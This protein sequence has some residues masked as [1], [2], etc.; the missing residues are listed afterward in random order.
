MIIISD[1]ITAMIDLYLKQSDSHIQISMLLQNLQQNLK[2]SD[3]IESSS[4]SVFSLIQKIIDKTPSLGPIDF[5]L[6]LS[7]IC[8]FNFHKVSNVRLSYNQIIHRCLVTD[9]NFF[10]S[11]QDMSDLFRLTVQALVIE[12]NKEIVKQLKQN[13]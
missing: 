13:I 2:K 5:K 3:E 11:I 6:Q 12:R 1:I 4:I 10:E 7:T 8:P 9:I